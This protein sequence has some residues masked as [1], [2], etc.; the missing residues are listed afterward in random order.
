MQITVERTD[1]V[2]RLMKV[3]IPE[4]QVADE[5]RNRLRSLTRTVRLPGFRPGK[6]PLKVIAHQY[7]RRVRNEVVGE[8]IRTTFEDAL[9][10]EKLR[11]AG[12]PTIDP[13][14]AHPGEGLSYTAVFEVYPEITIAA[15]DGL[16][17]R[18]PTAQVTEADVDRT[19]EK[20]RHQRKVWGT[21]E[22]PARLGDRVTMD[23]EARLD[24][25]SE[26]VDK[27][28][29]VKMELGGNKRFKDLQEGLIGAIPGTERNIQ[30]F[31]PGDYSV[32]ELAGKSA[33]W[34][35][36]V[37]TVEAATIPN[38]DNEFASNLGIE[39]GGVDALRMAVRENMERELGQA[40]ATETK[41]RVVEALLAANK[42]EV[43]KALVEAEKRG[44]AKN[45]GEA[46][47][48]LGLDPARFPT[49]ETA[50]GEQAKHR[51]ATG[52]LLAELVSKNGITVDPGKVRKRV[53][54]MAQGFESPEQVVQWYYAQPERLADVEAA[55][56]EEQVIAWMLERADVTDENTSFD[57]LLNREQTTEQTI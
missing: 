44:M 15:V 50:L 4:E 47:A 13:V 11:L 6:A 2:E 18:R 1:T 40:I 16:K 41:R 56:L 28:E 37:R 3:D 45:R 51:V 49:D 33:A 14:K 39:E 17:I 8:M 35:V 7:G 57:E 55:L 52:L 25:V 5:V 24:D 19:L 38:L 48:R 12:V 36:S 53:E 10:R 54:V 46:L 9:V 31:Y 30:V 43:P 21:A 42:V 34:K 29:G 27:G 23:Y 32:T 22:Q 26:A 20:L